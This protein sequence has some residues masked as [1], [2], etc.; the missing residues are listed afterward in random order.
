MTAISTQR[1]LAALAVLKLASAVSI[2]SLQ[3]DQTDD[4]GNLVE[5]KDK[6][7]MFETEKDK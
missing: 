5:V 6:N 1:I 2:S 3:E 4:Q 7:W